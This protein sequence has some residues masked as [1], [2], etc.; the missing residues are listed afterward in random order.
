MS[1]CAQRFRTIAKAFE[2]TASK[3]Q[4]SMLGAWAAETYHKGTIAGELQ[5]PEIDNWVWPQP[6]LPAGGGGSLAEDHKMRCLYEVLW[7]ILF[8]AHHDDLPRNSLGLTYP[9]QVAVGVTVSVSDPEG[10]QQ[11]ACASAMLCHMLA[12]RLEGGIDLSQTAELQFVDEG[13]DD[14]PKH[15][16]RI[17]LK[18]CRAILDGKA[19]EVSGDAARLLHEILMSYPAR[20]YA[21]RL[22]IEPARVR[23]K[24]P[25]SLKVAFVSE[26][27]RGCTLDPSKLPPK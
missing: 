19:F 22:G 8:L 24:L 10:W 25:R 7:P 27:G 13:R 4:F 23:T 15:R 26:R 1:E 17:D 11:R 18:N 12:D 2:T 9:E 3:Q 14:H 6:A 5:P 21:N 20:V 16:L